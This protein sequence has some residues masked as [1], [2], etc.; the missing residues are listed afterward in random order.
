[1]QHQ[2][3]LCEKNMYINLSWLLYRQLRQALPGIRCSSCTCLRPLCRCS[4]GHTRHSPRGSRNS[5]SSCRRGICR[6]RRCRSQHSC[7]SCQWGQEQLGSIWKKGKVRDPKQV[8]KHI[9][10][11]SGRCT[12]KFLRK[13]H[14]EFVFFFLQWCAPIYIPI[15]SAQGSLL[16]ILSSTLEYIFLINHLN[17][18][19]CLTL[20][21]LTQGT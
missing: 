5:S 1:M 8:Q 2:V 16:S 17:M 15:N 9:P 12:L 3:R 10:W 13:C 20:L 4:S 18:K 6:P 7:R 21:L 19:F 11:S 14:I